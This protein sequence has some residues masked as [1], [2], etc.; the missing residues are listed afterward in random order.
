MMI[1]NN[2]QRYSY[3]KYSE[4]NISLD[5]IGD[6]LEYDFIRDHILRELFYL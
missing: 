4:A 6:L 3:L 5:F 1:C 2:L